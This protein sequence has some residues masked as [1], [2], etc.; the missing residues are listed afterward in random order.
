MLFKGFGR[1]QYTNG[2]VEDP[3][4]ACNSISM[5]LERDHAQDLSF[6]VDRAGRQ[7]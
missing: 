6:A 2:E 5:A 1:A 7:H 4:V 3:R